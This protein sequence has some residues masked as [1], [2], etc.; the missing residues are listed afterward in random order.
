MPGGRIKSLFLAV[1]PTA[2]GTDHCCCIKLPSAA[3]AELGNIASRSTVATCMSCCT[4]SAGK[5]KP[6]LL[7]PSVLANTAA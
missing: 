4:I 1:A 3:A 2:A 5:G 7:L 6:L